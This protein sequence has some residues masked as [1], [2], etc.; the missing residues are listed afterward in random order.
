MTS[1][2][3]LRMRGWFMNCKEFGK[4]LL[5][6]NRGNIPV[7]TFIDCRKSWNTSI[8]IASVPVEIWTE[9]LPNASLECY[10]CKHKKKKATSWSESGR[11]L[12]RK[13]D[14]RLSAKLVP[15]FE[16][17]GCHVV[18]VTDP[19]GRILGFLDR[20]RYFFFQIA[21]QLYSRGWVDPVPDPLLRK[22]CSAGNRTR[23]SGSVVRNSDHQTKQRCNLKTCFT[24]Q[25]IIFNSSVHFSLPSSQIMITRNIVKWWKC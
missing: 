3:W 5:W 14:R 9:Y 8:R 2:S 1:A 24:W 23:T 7:F 6:S 11:E 15:T 16:D 25:K 17:R 18:N 20:S 13:S 22:S 21:P 19:Y 12:Y 10:Q 4:K